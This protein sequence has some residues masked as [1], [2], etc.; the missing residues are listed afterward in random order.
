M[1]RDRAGI[2]FK[3][4]M[5]QVHAYGK[6]S[7]EMLQSTECFDSPQSDACFSNFKSATED[8]NYKKILGFGI[9]KLDQSK[10]SKFDQYYDVIQGQN[11]DKEFFGYGDD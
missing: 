1:E 5:K 4:I 6:S 11:E 10:P 2:L 7:S 3:N 9:N 8:I